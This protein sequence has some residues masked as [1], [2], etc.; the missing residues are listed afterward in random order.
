MKLI[1]DYEFNL[2]PIW[3]QITRLPLG[4]MNQRT[5]EDLG[6]KI[7]AVE[8][9]EIDSD[10]KAVGKFLRVKVKLNITKPILRGSM[11]EIDES[12]RTGWCPFAY[13][14]LPDFCYVC[15]IIGHTEKE[16]KHKLDRGERAQYGSWL[17]ADVERRWG[18]DRSR[19]GFT[20]SRSSFGG[21]PGRFFKRGVAR[22]VIV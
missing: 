6:R 5:G 8:E 18:E 16:C 2:V 3:V 20:G 12:G 11:I 13:E 22:G 19:G 14:Y 7:G 17:R 15:G 4:M 21:R 9:V 10:G 1:E